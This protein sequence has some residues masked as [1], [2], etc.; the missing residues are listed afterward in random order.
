[1]GE[2]I[3]SAIEREKQIKSWVRQKKVALVSAFNSDWHDLYP[4]ISGVE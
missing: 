2:D 3:I 4:E 1:M